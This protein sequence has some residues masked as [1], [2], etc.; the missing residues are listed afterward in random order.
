MLRHDRQRAIR[1]LSRGLAIV[2][3]ATSSHDSRVLRT[4]KWIADC[5]MAQ[6]LGRAHVDMV[7]RQLLRVLAV[8]EGELGSVHADVADT[9]DSLALLLRLDKR[10]EQ[11]R[12]PHTVCWHTCSRH[13]VQSRVLSERARDIRV[14]LALRTGGF[15]AALAALGSD[16][17][18][19][20]PIASSQQAEEERLES[21]LMQQVCF[22]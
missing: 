17:D 3:Q 19:E 4:M 12:T 18:Q 7:A 11:V 9:L 20:I 21:E 15:S 6:S 10:A 2:E 13:H 8:Q 14:Q 16:R 1:Y 22:L 5:M